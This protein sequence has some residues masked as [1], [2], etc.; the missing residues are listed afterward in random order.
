MARKSS[1]CCQCAANSSA[2]SISRSAEIE[3]VELHFVDQPGK[4]AG[5]LQGPIRWNLPFS[6][7]DQPG[8]QQAAAERRNRGLQ[9]EVVGKPGLGFRADGDFI[10]IEFAE[11]ED[12]RQEQRVAVRRF[13]CERL[14]Q[15]APRAVRR[16]QHGVVGEASGCR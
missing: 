3:A 14:D 11:R 4:R 5:K 2:T 6:L 7:H 1:V 12:A 16:Q 13:L 15:R 9:A 8:E 10:R